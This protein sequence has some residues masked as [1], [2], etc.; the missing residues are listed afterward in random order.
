[1]PFEQGSPTFGLNDGKIQN[2]SSAGVYNG[3]LTDVMSIQLGSVT[4]K[5]VSAILTGD[6]RQTAIAAMAIGGTVQMR[7]GGL[8]PVMMGVLTGKTV[9]TIASVNQL[10]IK[11]S[12]RMPYIGIILKALSAETGDTWLFLP[13]CKIISDFTF[14]QMEYGAFATPEVTLEIVD[15][16]SY[17]VINV[18]THPTDLAI[19]VMP[20]ANIAVV[21]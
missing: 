3:T 13:K 10:N 1:M 17:G 19:T 20:P 21:S 16:A 6:D 5:L 4:Q 11:G 2:W 9:T 8:N 15:D 12:D 14:M 18:I 7:F